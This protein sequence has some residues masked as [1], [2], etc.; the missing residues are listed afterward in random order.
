MCSLP[1]KPEMTFVVATT[2]NQNE[3]TH[4]RSQRWTVMRDV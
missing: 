1:K 4:Q 2:N 3:P